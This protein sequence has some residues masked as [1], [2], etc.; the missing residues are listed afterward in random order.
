MQNE[1]APLA[2][3][4]GKAKRFKSDV[5]SIIAFENN[6]HP[7]FEGLAQISEAGDSMYSIGWS[8]PVPAGWLLEID[9]QVNELIW[10]GQLPD[11]AEDNVSED[12]VSEESV[13]RLDRTHVTQMLE[14]VELTQPGP[15]SERTIEMGDYFGI[16]ENG[17]LIAMAGERL[18]AG[19]FREI[20]GVCTRPGHQ[21]RG[22]ARMLMNKLIRLECDRDQIPFLHVV[23]GND[24]ALDIYLRMGF[25]H[26][27]KVALRKFRKQ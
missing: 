26:I 12:N 16:V 24:H 23:E 7:D 18:H 4:S 5:S 25:A 19:R 8:G 15:F 20:S 13:I 22:L 9:A 3:S 10:Q 27:H 21:G 17:R 1:Q 2:I 14:L 11:Q 6:D